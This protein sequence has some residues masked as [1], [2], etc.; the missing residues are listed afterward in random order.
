ME[1]LSRLYDRKIFSLYLHTLYDI[2]N[3]R[4][5]NNKK[6]IKRCIYAESILWGNG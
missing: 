3:W 2:M 5:I 4:E 1:L 6:P